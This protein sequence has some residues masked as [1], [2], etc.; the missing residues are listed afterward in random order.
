MSVA[1]TSCISSS[2][3]L[4]SSISDISGHSP[5]ISYCGIL[6]FRVY[7]SS[8]ISSPSSSSPTENPNWLISMF[9]I[10]CISFP[11]KSSS[12]SA[13]SAVLLSASR[14]ALICSSDKSSALIHGMSVIPS[15]FAALYRVCPAT[16]TPSLSMITGFLNPNC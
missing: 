11:S 15:F 10:P 12:H 2:A 13:S 7:L 14:N 1:S 16:I 4:L 5:V 6:T 9:M 3:L 8:C